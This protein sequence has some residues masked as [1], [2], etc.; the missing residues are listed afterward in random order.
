MLGEPPD[1]RNRTAT[2]RGPQNDLN[3]GLRPHKAAD[4]HCGF[5]IACAQG[6]ERK[7]HNSDPEGQGYSVKSV[8]LSSRLNGEPEPESEP[9]DDE[10]IGDS[11]FPEIHACNR[12]DP[13]L[14]DR[15]RR[16]LEHDEF[17]RD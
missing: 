8:S 11:P 3:H 2:Y 1:P 9:Q 15:C 16:C 7:W 14:E 4:D 5:H 10:G 13:C 17:K 6:I 12:T